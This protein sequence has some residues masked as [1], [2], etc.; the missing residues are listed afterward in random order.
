MA[1][2][3]SKPVEKPVEKP[4][5]S[6]SASRSRKTAVAPAAAPATR[7]SARGAA[8]AAAVDSS[9]STTPE[10]DTYAQLVTPQGA[11]E[12]WYSA[13]AGVVTTLAPLFL[14]VGLV[15]YFHSLVF[16]EP[17][18]GTATKSRPTALLGVVYIIIFALTVAS[19]AAFGLPAIL[20]GRLLESLTYGTRITWEVVL[21]CVTPAVAISAA[22]YLT[23]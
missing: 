22:Y 18:A 19:S 14:S 3:R 6:R 2:K 7:K 13:V 5:R 10:E 20:L 16:E 11:L 4:A 8:A 12:H 21:L 15:C 23:R 9:S 17:K 1:P